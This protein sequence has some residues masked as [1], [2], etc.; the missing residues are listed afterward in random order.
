MYL[1]VVHGCN[2]V[3]IIAKFR[4]N[5]KNYF[6][7]FFYSCQEQYSLL[8]VF[9]KLFHSCWP[10]NQL[11][12]FI[13]PSQNCFI[14]IFLTLLFLNVFSNSNLKK[15]FYK[16]CLE[17]LAFITSFARSL[18]VFQQV[19]TYCA[20]YANVSAFLF[21]IFLKICRECLQKHFCTMHNRSEPTKKIH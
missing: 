9:L 17:I 19:I 7:H 3:D 16:I 11:I 6:L 1:P 12:L 10:K 2:V 21:M 20:S 4:F 5:R 13:E 14:S 15:V 8:T 18:N